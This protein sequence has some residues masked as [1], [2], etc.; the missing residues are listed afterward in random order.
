MKIKSMSSALADIGKIA[1]SHGSVTRFLSGFRQMKD[2]PLKT[3]YLLE[4]FPKNSGKFLKILDE[5]EHHREIKV[6]MG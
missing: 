5:N 1:I 6:F 4:K 3:I 2:K